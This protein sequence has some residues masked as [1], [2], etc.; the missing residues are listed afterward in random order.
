LTARVRESTV[1]RARP[2]SRPKAATLAG[3]PLYLARS[4]RPLERI[5][6]ASGGFSVPLIRMCKELTVQP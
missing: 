6:D 2:K 5:V 3:E 1:D 4:Y